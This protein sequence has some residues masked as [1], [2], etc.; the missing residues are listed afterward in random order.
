MDLMTT[1]A[2]FDI[3]GLNPIVNSRH[4]N[5]KYEDI[6][7]MD[8]PD[9]REYIQNMRA[10]V[11]RLWVEHDIPP[12]RGWSEQDIKDDLTA[13]SKFN[14]SQ[15][16]TTDA[17]TGGKVIHNTFRQGNSMNAWN[18]SRM[19]KVRINYTE[20]DDGR[21]I[22]DFFNNDDLFER[23]MP[24][25]YRHFYRDSF[26]FF[27]QTVKGGDAIPHREALVP[28]TPM[29]YVRAFHEHTKPYNDH[30]LLIE[31]KPKDR[32]YTGY[33]EHLKGAEFFALSWDECSECIN[34]GW[35]NAGN[36]RLVGR[37]PTKTIIKAPTDQDYHIRLLRLGQRVFP[38]LFKSFRISMCQYAVNFPPLTARALYE[39]YLPKGQD[40]V[41]V[42]DPSAGWGG[43]ILG[44]MSSD[45][46]SASGSSSRLHYLGTD[47]NPDFYADGT[48][49]YASVANFYNA[50]KE[51]D[52]MFDESHTFKVFPCGSEMVRAV[53]AF[54]AYKG[55]LD[56]VFT[57]P[58]YFAKEAYCDDPR[59]SFKRFPTYAGWRDG[60]LEKTLA[61]AYEWLAPG[62]KLLWNIADV[63]FGKETH[64]LEQ[65]SIDIATKLGFTL[66][67]KVMMT[68]KSMPGANRIDEN[69]E[70]TTK[71]CCK[72][73]GRLMKYEPIYVFEKV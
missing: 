68:L 49:M 54:Q 62:R 40:R 30:M 66:V 67:E 38:D 46:R 6:L 64:P 12:A 10:E 41:T 59:Q 58:P 47:P 39:H 53:P 69:G 61:T 60:F 29:E 70:T 32:E 24:Y 14:T 31:A 16:W 52:N 51:S 36:M 9:F 55:K 57:S 11:K 45:I 1:S 63:K 5:L 18:L 25:A 19:L 48:S 50:L 27:A 65:D 42:W 43:R 71:N 21:S 34:N 23:Y 28:K 56:L 3:T 22:F 7:A 20:N 17:L 13:L 72:V 26:Y 35:L 15:L 2:P 4:I 37:G 33:A 73:N 44:A 8:M